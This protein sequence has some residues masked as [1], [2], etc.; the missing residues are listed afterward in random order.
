MILLYWFKDGERVLTTSPAS[1]PAFIAGILRSLFA[2]TLLVS[3]Q[4]STLFSTSPVDF[5]APILTAVA[6][7]RA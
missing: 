5:V 3:A 4:A 2:A 1:P 6:G 7:N